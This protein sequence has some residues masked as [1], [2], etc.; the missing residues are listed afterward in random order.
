LK[1]YKLRIDGRD[2]ESVIIP[3]LPLKQN[4]EIYLGRGVS[5]ALVNVEGQPMFLGTRAFTEAWDCVNAWVAV[6]ISEK[7][8]PNVI[9]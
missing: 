2:W 7:S 3:E 5:A 8:E 1:E 6:P 9:Q 4:E